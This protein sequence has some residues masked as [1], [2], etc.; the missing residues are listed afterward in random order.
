MAKRGKNLWAT[1][2]GSYFVIFV[3]IGSMFPFDR[4]I[5]VMDEWAS[6]N[7]NQDVFA[8]IGGD[9]PACEYAL[10]THYSARRIQECRK[11]ELSDGRTCG[12]R[13]RLHRR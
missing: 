9:L 8:Q 2:L 6:K 7:A 3:T 10:A 11:V 12:N 1:S 5:R 13:Q 4:M